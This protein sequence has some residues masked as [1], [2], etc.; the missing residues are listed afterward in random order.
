MG[1]Y[2]LLSIFVH[3]TNTLSL[4]LLISLRH[5]GKQGFLKMLSSSLHMC[6]LGLYLTLNYE[7][8]MV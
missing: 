4:D 7:Q 2:M 5:F 3:P 1:V 6:N 8:N